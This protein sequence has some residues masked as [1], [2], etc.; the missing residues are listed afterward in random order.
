MYFFIF[1]LYFFISCL[2]KYTPS[3]TTFRVT[4][5]IG[6]AGK[7]VSCDVTEICFLSYLW[8]RQSLTLKTNLVF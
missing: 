2:F 8:R 1:C 6:I 4:L 3:R 5:K 7:T